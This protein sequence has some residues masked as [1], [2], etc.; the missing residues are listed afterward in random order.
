VTFFRAQPMAFV[1]GS[2]C[3]VQFAANPKFACYLKEKFAIERMSQRPGAVCPVF[4]GI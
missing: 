3:R 2:L 4:S 1:E